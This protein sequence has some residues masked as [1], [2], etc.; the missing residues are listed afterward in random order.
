AVGE[1]G[2]DGPV[3]QP[4]RQGFLLRGCAFPSE[5]SAGD[6]AARVHALPV[7]DREWEEVLDVLRRLRGDAGGEYHRAAV[8]DDDRS[9]CLF[10][11]LAGLDGERPAVDLDLHRVSH[12]ND[13]PRAPGF[14]LSEDQS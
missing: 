4:G 6:P 13:R 8:A 14:S 3:D 9:V 7:L 10:G 5:V 11:N 12:L 2:A 1:K